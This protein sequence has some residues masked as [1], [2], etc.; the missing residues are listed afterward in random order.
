MIASS[1]EKYFTVGLDL[2]QVS[3]DFT[4]SNQEKDVARQALTFLENGPIKTMQHAISALEECRKPIIAAINSYCI[5][6]G[7]DLISA[8]DI[9][10][11]SSDSIFSV[12]EVVVGLAADLGTLQRLPKIVGN[13]SWVRE[14]CLTG[15]DFKAQEVNCCYVKAYT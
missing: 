2:Q 11:C 1:L 7:I 3:L 9:R 4:A 13:Q 12:R 8:A 5:G 10:L 6:G 15:R 14:I